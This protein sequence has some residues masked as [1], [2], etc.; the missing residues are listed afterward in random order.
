MN[1]ERIST[2]QVTLNR[3]P[4]EQ[5]TNN[6][7][8]GDEAQSPRPKFITYNYSTTVVFLF[9]L[10]SILFLFLVSQ[11]PSECQSF[12]FQSHH[13]LSVCILMRRE[14]RLHGES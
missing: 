12:S 5:A 11:N 2:F 4:S 6:C 13:Q 14:S 8:T 3:N 7:S 9:K 10:P 1:L